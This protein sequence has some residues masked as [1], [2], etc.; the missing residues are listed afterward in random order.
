MLIHN[1]IPKVSLQPINWTRKE[2]L[3]FTG[4]GPFPSYLKRFNLVETLVCSCGENLHPNP[5]CLGMP[6]HSL[7]PYG[8]TQLTTSASLVP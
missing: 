3:F 6:P 7:L 8:T 1:I 5:F 4:H 2:V